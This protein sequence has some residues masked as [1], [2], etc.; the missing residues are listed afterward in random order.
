MVC[1]QI[2]AGLREQA[3]LSGAG[4]LCHL[5]FAG[6]EPEISCGASHI[7]DIAL[8]I[9]LL[10]QKPCLLQ[11]GFMAPDLDDPSLVEGQGAE[12]AAAKAAPVADEAELHL[13]DGRN[14]PQGLIG[15]M[16]RPHIGKGVHVVHF[17]SGKGLCRRILD[18]IEMVRIRLTE[19]F[20]RKRIGVLVLGKKALRIGALIFPH[21]VVGRQPDCIIN[22]LPPVRLIDGAVDKGNILNIDPRSQGICDLHDGPFPHTVGNKIRLGIHQDGML[23]LSGPV[24]VVGQ[25]AQAGLD[26]ADD[27]GSL[28]ID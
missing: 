10:R 21:L 7:V 9:R 13:T 3:L 22:G 16:G 4:P 2:F 11:N 17:Q 12:A 15:R 26:P 14:A 19:T 5:L 24:I 20:S 6:R 1:H 25:A 18:H 8:E 27:N 28:L 23:H